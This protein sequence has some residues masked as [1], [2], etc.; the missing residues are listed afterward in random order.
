MKNKF[1]PFVIVF[2]TFFITCGNTAKRKNLEYE[3]P[4]ITIYEENQIRRIDKDHTAVTENDNEP[5]PNQK[6]KVIELNSKEFRKRVYDYYT[7]KQWKY[8]GDKPCIIDFYANWCAPCRRL[9]PILE[10]LAKQYQD[11]IYVYKV[12]TD[13]ELEL[14]SIFGIQRLPT[15]IFCPLNSEPF[16]QEGLLSINDY[17][18]IINKYLLNN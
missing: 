4:N 1:L 14:T 9:S 10:E 3:M 11:K 18:M 16:R 13:I 12:N 8:K 5:Q 17:K 15:L 6:G 2:S 7:S